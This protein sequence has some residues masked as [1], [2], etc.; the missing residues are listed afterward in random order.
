MLSLLIVTNTFSSGIRLGFLAILQMKWQLHKNFKNL[1][2][3]FFENFE[4]K[5]MQL[6]LHICAPNGKRN[7]VLHTKLTWMMYHK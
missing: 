2:Y 7:N 1:V 5:N 6:I 3:C 4:H